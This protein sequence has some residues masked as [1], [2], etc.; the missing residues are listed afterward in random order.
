[1]NTHNDSNQ[2]G[3]SLGERAVQAW[4]RFWF[5][6]FDPTLWAIIRIFC[7][8]IILY[9]FLA[10]SYD[11]QDFFGEHAWWDLKA[12]QRDI[13]D[14]PAA[15]Q[16]LARWMNVPPVPQT[17]FQT[18]YAE[19]YKLHHKTLPPAP[20]P[21]NDKQVLLAERYIQDFNADF[22]LYNMPFPENKAQEDY[23]W[24][25]TFEF[26][27]PPAPPYPET[28]EQ[29][30][31]INEYIRRY[32]IDPRRLYARGTPI[33]SIYF[34]VTD[35]TWMLVIHCGV[36]A[37]ALC[38]TL[39]LATRVT[40]VLLWIGHMFYIHRNPQVL[41]GVDTMMT[42]LL[43]YMMIAPTAAALSLDRIMARWWQRSRGRIINGWRSLWFKEPVVLPPGPGVLPAPEPS[44]SA[45]FALRLLQIHVCIVYIAAGLSKL[46]G[47]SWWS[48]TAIWGTLAN[49]EFA[50]MQFEIYNK[51]L[52][53]LGANKMVF[54]GFLTLGTYFTLTFEITYTFLIWRRA[55]RWLML[56]MAIVLHGFIGMFMGLKTF[57]L[58]MLAMNMAFLR[59]EEVKWMLGL[60]GW[61]VRKIQVAPVPMVAGREPQR[62]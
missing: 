8:V 52:R 46:L 59:P 58:V 30:E 55:T 40:T 3:R 23:L 5:T 60:V 53:L 16:P 36:I 31:E 28:K 51:F 26:K 56:G 18:E 44:V 37:L 7:G 1:L 29:E 19:R 47:Q 35:P 62:V 13:R 14:K 4:D 45:N 33:W 17:P 15:V 22:R 12:A 9:T 50:P 2:S 49:Y 25:F 39:G 10:Y 41:F 54:M 43:L 42:I 24:R 61:K 48:G 6:P 34:H 20:Y 32:R 21:E 57:S 38:F 27:M 11:F